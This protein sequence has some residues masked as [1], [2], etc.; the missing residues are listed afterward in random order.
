MRYSVAPLVFPGTAWEARRFYSLNG[1]DSSESYLQVLNV[2]EKKFHL[3]PTK[4]TDNI[5]YFTVEYA[6]REGTFRVVLHDD[7]DCFFEPL[8]SSEPNDDWL[9]TLMNAVMTKLEQVL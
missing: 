8:Q 1:V 3:T 9:L 6:C 4:R 7:W 2:L 5:W